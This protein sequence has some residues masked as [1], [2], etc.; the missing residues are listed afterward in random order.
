M[1]VEGGKKQQI[2]STKDVILPAWS[3]DGSK[4]AFLQRAGKT[5]FDLYVVTVTP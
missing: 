3:T 4:I 5:K 2:D 1:S